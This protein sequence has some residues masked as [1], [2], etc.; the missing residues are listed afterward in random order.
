ML[1][2]VNDRLS[3]ILRRGEVVSISLEVEL[4][5]TIAVFGGDS[6]G[7]WCENS[8]C[9]N[10]GDRFLVRIPH[11]ECRPIARIGTVSAIATVANSSGTMRSLRFSD[12]NINHRFEGE[13]YL[14][15]LPDLRGFFW[16]GI[17]SNKPI[18]TPSPERMTMSTIAESNRILI[19]NGDIGIGDLITCRRA[20]LIDVRALSV[21]RSGNTQRV[22][23]DRP[24]SMTVNNAA[25]TRIAGSMFD[26][27]FT[28]YSNDPARFTASTSSGNTAIASSNQILHLG[29][30]EFYLCCGT[31]TRN[32]KESAIVLHAMSLPTYLL[33]DLL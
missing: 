22:V 1:Q 17:T 13:G 18:G 28:G 5:K 33:P 11:N 7:I 9:I 21:E 31:N 12:I 10:V 27:T 29:T 3:L 14:A 25:A 26:W 32:P 20:E 19:R 6:T 8:P 15:K 16:R 4:G 2:T 23:I 30:T 24:C